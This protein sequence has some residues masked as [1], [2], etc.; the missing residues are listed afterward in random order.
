MS[1]ELRHINSQVIPELFST[2]VSKDENIELLRRGLSLLVTC[3][4]FEHQYPDKKEKSIE[5]YSGNSQI[6]EIYLLRVCIAH[7]FPFLKL[8]ETDGRV[9]NIAERIYSEGF[10]LKGVSLVSDRPYLSSSYKQQ[11]I[12]GILSKKLEF[13]DLALGSDNLAAAGA[14]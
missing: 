10:S 7:G 2:A 8:K 13:K 14:K 1:V 9:K 11:D 12:Q 3:M 6:E 5:K 4:A